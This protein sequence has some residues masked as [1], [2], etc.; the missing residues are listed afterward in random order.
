MAGA[1]RRPFLVTE[2]LLSEF[3]VSSGVFDVDLIV[4]TGTWHSVF[5][6]VLTQAGLNRPIKLAP[7]AEAQQNGRQAGRLG[8]KSAKK[9]RS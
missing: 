5:R 2:P 4:P 6:G 3:A 9:Q 8:E 7:Q 1:E